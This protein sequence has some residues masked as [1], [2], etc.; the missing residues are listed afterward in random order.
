MIT[1]YVYYIQ[2]YT[3]T[4]LNI[5]DS[6]VHRVYVPRNIFRTRIQRER[7]S[8]KIKC[9]I[10]KTEFRQRYQLKLERAN[11]GIAVGHG[12]I[13]QKKVQS[14]DKRS[15]NGTPRL[16]AKDERALTVSEVSPR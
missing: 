4:R 2:I 14:R 9:I 16:P 5:F 3:K 11:D 7:D 13:G 8:E 6:L 1:A 10:Y 15:H 12:F